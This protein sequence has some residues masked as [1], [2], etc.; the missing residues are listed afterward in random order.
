M[1]ANICL[2][3]LFCTVWS[4]VTA[5]SLLIGAFNIQIFGRSKMDKPEVVDILAKIV[6]RYDIVMIQEIRDSSQESLP[7][8]VN[9]VNK[10]SSH[11]YQYV[12]SMRTGRTSNKEQYGYIYRT[13]KVSVL[14]TYQYPDTRDIFEREPFTVQFRRLD[15]NFDGP[16][17][18]TYISLHSKP[19]DA[20]A[21]ISA[22]VEVYDIVQRIYGDES[23]LAG[24]FNADCNYVCK[25]CWDD[26]NLWTDDR[27]KW[28]LGNEIDTTVS[29]TDCAYD[30]VVVTGDK[31]IENSRQAQVFRFDLEYG[32][33]YE[34]T[35]DV[36]D[37]YPVE[38]KLF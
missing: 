20:Q 7:E 10:I 14:S 9:E 36:S 13:D 21:E 35:A 34:Q 8:L 19:D 31:V 17:D 6:N 26:I 5:D 16:R 1:K 37:H 11:N 28:L 2:V 25:S 18:F 32:L 23:I 30:R 3:L 27:F 38:F 24:D 33:S 15:A 29:S 22:M 12:V 4:L